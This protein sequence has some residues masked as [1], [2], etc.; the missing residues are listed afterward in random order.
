MSQWVAL[1][2]A[3]QAVE[4][5]QAAPPAPALSPA[6]APA[7][8]AGRPSAPRKI[9][10]SR[11]LTGMVPQGSYEER[12]RGAFARTQSL[13]G[14]LDGAW[15]LKDAGGSSLYRVQLVDHGYAGS[16]LEGVWSDLKAGPGAAAT[17]F[18]A[19]AVRDGDRLTLR[20][21]EAP[22]AV[23]TLDFQAGAGFAG[24]LK[25][26]ETEQPVTMVRP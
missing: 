18:L 7:P 16:P 12:L 13:Q 5:S 22:G 26:G 4:P 25:T 9:D 6:P 19:S 1:W 8:P 17:G 20:F 11:P 14:P 23:A 3:M 24:A 15:V 10:D 21:T 2:L